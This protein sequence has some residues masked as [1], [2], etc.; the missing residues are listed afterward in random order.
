MGSA[1]ECKNKCIM[2]KQCKQMSFG[3]KNLKKGWNSCF[4]F[5]T[6]NRRTSDTDWGSWFKSE[7]WISILLA[8][9]YILHHI[10]LFYYISSNTST[11]TSNAINHVGSALMGSLR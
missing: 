1:E 11:S 4:L 6:Y 3:L 9:Y 7:G 10:G 2:D 8:F 5:V